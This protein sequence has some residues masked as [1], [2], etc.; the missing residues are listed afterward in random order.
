M[1]NYVHTELGPTANMG[2]ECPRCHRVFAPY[3]SQCVSC[4]EPS[5]TVTNPKWIKPDWGNPQPG[6]CYV[7]GN[8]HSPDMACPGVTIT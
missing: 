5:V 3:V 8:R 6:L 1:S 2:W 4:G 7:C